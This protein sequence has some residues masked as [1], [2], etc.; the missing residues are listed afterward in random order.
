M[1]IY[2]VEK[3]RYYTVSD[4]IKR[5]PNGKRSCYINITNRCTCDCTFCL[6]TKKKMAKTS[7]LWLK[8]EPSWEEIKYELD[9]LP[10]PLVS[11][12]VCCGFGE[13]T[14]RL[15]I[16]ISI[17][18]YVKSN[19]PNIHTRLNTNGLSDLYYQRSTAEDF[20]G[21]ILDT[22]SISLNASNADKYVELTRSHFGIQSYDH[23]LAFAKSCKTVVKEVVMTIVDTTLDK[24]EVA[25]CHQVCSCHGL[26]LRIRPYEEN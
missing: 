23:M 5:H 20:Y 22:I 12:I 4:S 24:E 18:Q 21:N 10:W 9:H 16:V 1:I 25:K 26:F 19:H 7:S 11:E 3:G 15:D 13:P 8:R 6:R 2:T 14:M 17:F